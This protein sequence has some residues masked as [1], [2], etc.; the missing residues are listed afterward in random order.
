MTAN[1]YIL[2]ELAANFIKNCELLDLKIEAKNNLGNVTI[3]G[4]PNLVQVKQQELTNIN[5]LE[6]EV[7]AMIKQ[8]KKIMKDKEVFLLQIKKLIKAIENFTDIAD[9]A[10]KK[11]DFITDKAQEIEGDFDEIRQ[12]LEDIA[13]KEADDD[14]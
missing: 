4:S 6:A 14:D 5:G 9:L 8:E 12:S 2:R 13:F 1:N 10:V 11:L 3:T 7:A